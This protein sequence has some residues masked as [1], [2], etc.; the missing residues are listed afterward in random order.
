MTRHTLPVILLFFAT[1]TA[2]AQPTPLELKGKSLAD[3]FG[4]LL[5]NF[6]SSNNG[7]RTAAQQRW[8]DICN[9]TGAPG[10]EKLRVEA[11]ELMA[12]KLDATTPTAS[13]HWLLA[14]LERIGREESVESVAAL[15]VDPDVEIREAAV[16]V[17]A[18][19][20]SPKAT[21]KLTA[22]LA[23]V[24][25]PTLNPEDTKTKIGL[26][27]ALGHRGDPAA[28][29]LIAKN[30]VGMGTAEVAAARA[31]GRIPG[32][33]SLKALSAA[34]PVAKESIRTAVSEALLV[35]A[36]RFLKAG[37]TADASGIYKALNST[38]EPRPVRL[39]ALRGFIQTEGDKAGETVLGILA[40]DDTGAQAIALGQI[41]NLPAG[42]LKTLAASLDKL[43]VPSRVGVIVAIAARGDKSQSPVAMS[44]AKSSDAAVKRAGIVALGRLGDVTVV[45]FLLE[46]MAGKDATAGIAADSLAALPAEGIEEK[47]IAV[48]D[49]EKIPARSIALIGILE[50]RRAVKGVPAFLKAAGNADASVRIAAFAGLK[51]LASPEHLPAMIAALSLT[52][53]GNERDRA[54][55]AIVAVSAQVSQAEKRAEPV[56]AVIKETLNDRREDLLPLLGRLGGAESL[57]VIRESLSST[58]GAVHDAA[59]V[60]VCNWPDTAANS[61][62]LA[63]AEKGKDAEKLRSLQSLIRVNTELIERTPEE[64]LDAL[65]VMKKAMVLAT[66][67]QERKAILEGLGNIRHLETLRYVVLYLD[68]PAF[69]QSVCKGVVEL[70]HS[71]MLREPNKAEFEMA[72]GR[73]IDLCKDKALVDR[74]KQYKEG[75]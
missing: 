45:E 44:A 39:A 23:K 56:L 58:D 71:K 54:E 43:P 48:L 28:V 61:D 42:A 19:N 16:R 26:L 49:A 10:N 52:A 20:P 66:R 24:T 55:L 3:T 22:K 57:K 68:Q 33:D 18:N 36:D 25:G 8:Q 41:E 60:G 70:A 21:E 5:P 29:L 62:L 75:R 1:L 30:L 53:K 7:M 64:R 13:R 69:V 59:F 38:D 46:A 4:E 9:S 73:V 17:L 27:N 34:R 51:T 67:D 35:H 40:G 65:N 15:L 31:L 2:S 32:E 37:K 50:R 47:L 12:A 11:C 6:H 63:L 74:A 72:L 14:Q